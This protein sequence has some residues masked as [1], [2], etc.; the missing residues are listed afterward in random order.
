MS[1]VPFHGIKHLLTDAFAILL[2][3]VFH[4]PPKCSL[5]WTVGTLSKRVLPLE[6]IRKTLE[7]SNLSPHDSPIGITVNLIEDFFS[8]KENTTSSCSAW[9]CFQFQPRNT[10]ARRAGWRVVRKRRPN[11]WC[12]RDFSWYRPLSRAMHWHV[13][14][15]LLILSSHLW[16]FAVWVFHV[17]TSAITLAKWPS[18]ELGNGDGGLWFR[19]LSVGRGSSTWTTNQH[20][21]VWFLHC[22]QKH[23]FHGWPSETGILN[24]L[25]RV[26]HH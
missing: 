3:Y 2:L 1:N 23:Y 21:P 19:L 11:C 8:R 26:R 15:F 6:Q 14:F 4:S 25:S 24:L 17:L 20:H 18:C 10:W 7:T 13:I 5:R 16:A 22:L 9:V 12:S